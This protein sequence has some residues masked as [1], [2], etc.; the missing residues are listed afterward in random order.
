MSQLIDVRPLNDF[1]LNHQE[2]IERLRRSGQPEVLTV[3][4]KA[5]LVIQ[6]AGAYEKL[7]HLAARAEAITGI[8]RG[9]ASM[10]RGEGRSM[11]EFLGE[12]R[13]RK[14]RSGE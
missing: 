8:Q 6:D 11:R 3:N 2:H 1:L 9:L 4:G 13:E 12:L 5:K 14:G 7:L 10:G